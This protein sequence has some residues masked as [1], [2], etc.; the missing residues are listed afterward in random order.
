M[1]FVWRQLFA[2]QR[3]GKKKN[4]SRKWAFW[5][6]SLHFKRLMHIFDDIQERE[7][8][9]MRYPFFFLKWFEINLGRTVDIN[10]S[11]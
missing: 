9:P 10:G 4:V 1:Y 6:E 3:R 8:N 2:P 11:C 7:R 5:F